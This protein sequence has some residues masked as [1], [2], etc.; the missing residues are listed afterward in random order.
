M[1]LKRNNFLAPRFRTTILT[2]ILTISVLSGIMIVDATHIEGH[3]AS[4]SG[5]L[6]FDREDLDFILKQ[7]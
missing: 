6:A 1:R 3:A 7:I 2:A 4:P 5:D